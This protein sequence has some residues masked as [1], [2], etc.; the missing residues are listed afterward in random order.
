MK[1]PTPSITFD[2]PLWLKATSIIKEE[3]LDIICR[4][5]GFHTLM[6]C[7]GSIGNLMNGS[8]I[9]ELFEEVYAGN[10]VIHMLSGKAIARSLRAHLLA[11]FSVILD[12]LIAKNK[13]DVTSLI[14]VYNTAIQGNL[15]QKD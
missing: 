4:L 1:I 3:N 9:K 2:Q 11:L 14:D 8:S 10:G 15:T 7:L 13:V 5:G 12:T 6:S